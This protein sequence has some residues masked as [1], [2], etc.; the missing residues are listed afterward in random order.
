[1]LQKVDH[2]TDNTSQ[3]GAVSQYVPGNGELRAGSSPA[4]GGA[5]V[6][7][8]PRPLGRRRGPKGKGGDTPAHDKVT[9]WAVRH[10]PS[11]VPFPLGSTL[12]HPHS[13]CVVGAGGVCTETRT[14]STYAAHTAS[15]KRVKGGG[16]EGGRK[17]SDDEREKE[18]QRARAMGGG[19]CVCVC[20]YFCLGT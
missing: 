13:E 10:D 9:H 5:G 4:E 17:Q 8:R 1:M 2:F 20:V 19:V 3:L 6:G 18:R 7:A 14:W 15:K 11:A 12:R 16:A